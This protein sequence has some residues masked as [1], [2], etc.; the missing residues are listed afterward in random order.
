MAAS[1]DYSEVVSMTTYVYA[2][3]YPYRILANLK[4]LEQGRV[5]AKTYITQFKPNEEYSGSHLYAQPAEWSY[6]KPRRPH[7]LVSAHS[8]GQGM[9]LREES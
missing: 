2:H 4:A 1:N 3:T 8:E 9:V 7:Y 5:H 6:S